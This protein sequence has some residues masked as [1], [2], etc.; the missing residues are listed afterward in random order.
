M[1]SRIL[2]QEALLLLVRAVR[3]QRRAE[4]FLTE[5]VDLVRGVGA[6]VLLVERDPVG[7]RQPTAAV[8][9]RPAQAGQTRRRQML[10]PRQA[11]FERLVLAPWPAQALERGEFADQIVGEPLADLGPEL[12]DLYHPCRLTYQALALLEERR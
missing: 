5:V 8:L 11:L 12:L 7:D 9:H 2:R 4:Q 3:D 6:G 10:V 1:T